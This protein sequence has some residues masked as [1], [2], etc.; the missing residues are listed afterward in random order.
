MS[1]TGNASLHHVTMTY[2][3]PGCLEGL[4]EIIRY[5]NGGMQTG[6]SFLLPLSSNEWTVSNM[7]TLIMHVYYHGKADGVAEG[8]VHALVCQVMFEGSTYQ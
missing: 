4:R 1:L 3:R 5:H 7:M 2:E 8:Y 6:P